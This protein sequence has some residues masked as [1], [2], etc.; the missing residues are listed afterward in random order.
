[1][2]MTTVRE[3]V[4]R[5][6]QSDV[7]TML[8]RN[9]LWDLLQHMLG[10]DLDQVHC[11]NAYLL[12]GSGLFIQLPREIDRRDPQMQATRALNCRLLALS[13]Q[14]RVDKHRNGGTT[15]SAYFRVRHPLDPETV[16]GVTFEQQTQCKAAH[17][18]KIVKEQEVVACGRPQV[19][20]ATAVI[21]LR[22]A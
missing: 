16:I 19:Y 21:D 5:D 1:M 10:E 9:A 17:R 4:D 3:N 8:K 13:G 2:A 11:S 6:L 18:Y 20:G 7:Q 22:A 14:E 12:S 15:V